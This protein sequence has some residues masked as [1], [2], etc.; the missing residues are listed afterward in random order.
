VIVSIVAWFSGRHPVESALELPI[1]AAAAAIFLLAI[2]DDSAWALSR[3]VSVRPLR[4]TGEISYGLYLW[5]VPLL[6][7]FGLAGL[8]FA[9][10]A[11]LLSYRYIEKPMRRK[12]SDSRS[13]GQT[14]VPSSKVSQQTAAAASTTA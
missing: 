11:T 4:A 10:L 9:L 2:L 7:F 6:V 3:L 8:P 13:A 5:H 12:R 1:F 14:I